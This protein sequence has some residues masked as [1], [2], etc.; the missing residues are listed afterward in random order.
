MDAIFDSTR[1]D[2]VRKPLLQ[3]HGLPA[4]C[5]HDARFFQRELGTVFARS[6]LM[7]GRA[8][9][10]PNTGDFFT[11]DQAGLSLVILRDRE[12]DIRAFVNACRH[13]GA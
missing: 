5:Y 8:D 12:G 10:I 3:A 11:H 4:D 1:Y 13:R 9:R 6:W 7:V 2:N